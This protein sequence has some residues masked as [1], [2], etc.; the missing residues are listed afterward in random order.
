MRE[1]VTT[2]FPEK[3]KQTVLPMRMLQHLKDEGNGDALC[4][5]IHAWGHHQQRKDSSDLVH[6]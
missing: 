5:V 2:S 3:G 1:F 4:K 6:H